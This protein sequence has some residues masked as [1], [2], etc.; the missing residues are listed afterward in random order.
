AR[1][2]MVVKRGTFLNRG[3]AIGPAL[4]R[5][6]AV[7]APDHPSPKRGAFERSS[8]RDRHVRAFY[9]RPLQPL[10][11][12]WRARLDRQLRQART[13]E[14]PDG[15]ADA[16]L[17]TVRKAP[18]VAGH[19]PG[20]LHLWPPGGKVAQHALV[21]VAR[22][23]VE[24]VDRAVLEPRGRGGAVVADDVHISGDRPD[25]LQEHLV[26]PAAL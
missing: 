21:A 14:I 20:R 26:E 24:E 10:L 4:A 1:W 17:A 5:A 13:E 22:V 15:I 25:I 12:R 16:K 19:Q 11:V 7:Q 3:E 2:L 6:A 8:R 9:D 18:V 23:D